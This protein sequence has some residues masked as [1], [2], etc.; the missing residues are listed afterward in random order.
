ME[1][2]R[3]TEILRG[4]LCGDLSEDDERVRNALLSSEWL[5]SELE[6]LRHAQGRLHEEER[7]RD[8]ILDE[9]AEVIDH[10][11]VAQRDE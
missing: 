3:P 5:R 4:L 8:E 2:R 11:R 1:S 9:V 10:V 7:E 6:M